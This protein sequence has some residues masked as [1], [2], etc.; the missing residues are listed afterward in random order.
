MKLSE[1]NEQIKADLMKFVNGEYDNHFNTDQ[2]AM[3]TELSFLLN[4]ISSEGDSIIFKYNNNKLKISGLY[5][6]PYI[7]EEEI[8]YHLKKEEIF[9]SSYKLFLREHKINKLLNE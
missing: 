4:H 1:T 2:I 3:V 9:K 6:N 8:F 7:T 5:D